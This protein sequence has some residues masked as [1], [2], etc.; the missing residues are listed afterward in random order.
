MTYSP[1]NRGTETPFRGVPLVQSKR[2]S[3]DLNYLSGVDKAQISWVRNQLMAGLEMAMDG[4]GTLGLASASYEAKRSERSSL[5][6]QQVARALGLSWL[7]PSY[8]QLV[9]T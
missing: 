2:A 5:G 6:W 1:S 8:Q 9:N 3:E 7:G 4:V